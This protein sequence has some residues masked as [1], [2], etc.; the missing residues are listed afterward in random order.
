MAAGEEDGNTVDAETRM[1]EAMGF[2]IGRVMGLWWREGGQK[3]LSTAPWMDSR[4]Q[5]ETREAGSEAGAGIGVAVVV[6]TVRKAMPPAV[7]ARVSFIVG[8]YLG[9]WCRWADEL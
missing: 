9:M 7:R 5:R 6:E 4:D 3:A 2:C 8:S 1:V